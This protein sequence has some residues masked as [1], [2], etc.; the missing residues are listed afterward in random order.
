MDL[1]DAL[2][3][4]SEILDEELAHPTVKYEQV[5]LT[6]AWAL[7]R[8]PVVKQNLQAQRQNRPREVEEQPGH[9]LFSSVNYDLLMAILGQVHKTDRNA[10]MASIVKRIPSAH[11]YRRDKDTAL[12]YPRFDWHVSEL[13]L[14]AEFCVR[15]GCLMLA[16][17]AAA[18]IPRPTY[19]LILFLMQLEEMIAL[20]FTIFT[21]RQLES[22]PQLLSNLREEAHRLT[23]SAKRP[24]GTTGPAIENPHYVP[25]FEALASEVMRS[26][27]GI[28]EECRKAHYFYL[29]NELQQTVNIE[30]ESDKAKVQSFLAQLGFRKQMLETLE[31]AEK[32]YRAE[33]TPFQLKNCLGHLRSFL[34][35]THRDAATSIATKLNETPPP[36][37]NTSVDFLKRKDILTAQH[38]KFARGLYT[39]LSDEGV[40]RL[41]AEREFARLLRNMVIE[42]GL[43][44]LT[45]LDKKGVKLN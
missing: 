42:Y 31:A 13:P 29:K 34:E 16:L 38:D 7:Q 9:Y 25:G 11:S 10:F 15:N 37:W 14:I 22:I 20:N 36:D 26:I 40:H 17:Q 5:N 28:T 1:A 2:K 8:G 3:R 27:D 4:A 6:R 44:F 35:F 33:S 32:D 18:S 30:I 39:L 43:M 12:V 19:G 21:A 41:I 23:Y 24:R 45:V